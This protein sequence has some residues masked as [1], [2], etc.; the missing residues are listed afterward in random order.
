MVDR[1]HCHGPMSIYFAPFIGLLV[2]GNQLSLRHGMVG[3]EPLLFSIL[4][5][6]RKSLWAGVS[7]AHSA[8]HPAFAPG[9]ALCV[10]GA[11]LVSPVLA[12]R[13]SVYAGGC[14]RPST[15][16]TASSSGTPHTLAGGFMD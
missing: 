14:C 2:A 11:A 16:D 15:N 6:L 10:R 3:N 8:S 9:A 1:P 5:S 12:S 7:L 13:S 4:V